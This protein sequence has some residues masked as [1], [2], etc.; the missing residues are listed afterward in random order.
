MK[1]MSNAYA[2]ARKKRGLSTAAA[3]DLLGVSEDELVRCER[4]EL[5]P[6]AVE[7]LHMARLYGTSADYL[8]GNHAD[9]GVG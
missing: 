3:A 5:I 7:V 2:N 4:G 6:D 1:H 9:D 8:I